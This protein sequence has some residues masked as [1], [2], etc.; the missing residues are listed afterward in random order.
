[1]ES[2]DFAAPSGVAAEA[3]VARAAGELGVEFDGSERA[4]LGRLAGAVADTELSARLASAPRLLREVPFAFAVADD[5]PLITGAIDALALELDGG[6]LVVDYKSDR[7]AGEDLEAVTEREYGIQ[8][9]VYALAALRSGALEVEVAHW[10]LERP[11]EPVLAHWSAAE[12]EALAD[13]VRARVRAVGA[14]DFAVSPNPHRDLCL[15]C[16]GRRALCSWDEEHTLRPRPP[17]PDADASGPA[18]RANGSSMGQS[19]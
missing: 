11:D 4:L 1:L 6:S 2:I 15:T 17:L 13:E 10:Y 3:A 8:R 18:K 12:A 19:G 7:V 9:R 14:S 16:P 5:Q